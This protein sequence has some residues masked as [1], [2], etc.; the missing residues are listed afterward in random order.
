MALTVPQMCTSDLNKKAAASSLH[1]YREKMFRHCWSYR[2]V[3]EPL[4]QW[5]GGE[6][7]QTPS[8]TRGARNGWIY[9]T[10][11]WFILTYTINHEAI[12]ERWKLYFPWRSLALR[13]SVNMHFA[14]E[15][16]E[17]DQF[18]GEHTGVWQNAVFSC[19]ISMHVFGATINCEVERYQLTAWNTSP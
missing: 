18:L 15:T 11:V 12:D 2:Q 9:I 13:G 7:E 3:L 5:Q 8:L 19:W 17:G 4:P 1:G 6:N 10:V 14:W 16:T